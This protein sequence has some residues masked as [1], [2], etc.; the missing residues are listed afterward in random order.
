MILTSTVTLAAIERAVEEAPIW[1]PADSLFTREQKVPASQLANAPE[2]LDQRTCG[3]SNGHYACPPLGGHPR[4]VEAEIMTRS[5]KKGG[6]EKDQLFGGPHHWSVH[7]GSPDDGL[8][9]SE[10][11]ASEYDSGLVDALYAG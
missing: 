7:Y 6:D 10:G 3:Y 4:D 2:V 8:R 5:S 11:D 9:R 1:S